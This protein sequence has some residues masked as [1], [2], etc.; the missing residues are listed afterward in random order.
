MVG[1]VVRL[2]GEAEYTIWF[3]GLLAG[4]TELIV[5]EGLK[6]VVKFPL[7]LTVSQFDANIKGKDYSPN[8]VTAHSKIE[9]GQIR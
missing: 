8:T 9:K 5:R 3:R 4:K 7:R 1:D 2:Q 6:E